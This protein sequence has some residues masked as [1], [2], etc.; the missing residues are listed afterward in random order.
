MKVTLPAVWP[1]KECAAN[2]VARTPGQYRTSRRDKCGLGQYRTSR[3]HSCG[4]G[5]VDTHTHGA[6]PRLWLWLWLALALAAQ[7][8]GLSPEAVTHGHAVTRAGAVTRSW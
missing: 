5:H 8:R 1:R 7:P 6:S 2:L 4:L 3:R